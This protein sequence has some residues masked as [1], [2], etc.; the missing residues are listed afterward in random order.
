[1]NGFVLVLCDV[2]TDRP[3]A[4][5]QLAV[6]TD[7]SAI[8]E[9]ALQPLAR[10][11]NYAETVF[12][13]P[14]AADGDARI[15][16]FTPTA[17]IP[18]A[19]HPT[20]GTAVVLATP[21][22][23]AEVRLET[24][25]GIV[26]IALRFEPGRPAFGRMRQ[27]VPQVT[28]V[29]D[30]LAA[31]LLAALGVARSRL[32]VERYDNGLLH[33]FVVLDD[34]AAVARLEPDFGALARLARA[35]NTPLVG[36]NCLAGSGRTWKTRMFAPADGIPEDSATGS[37]AGSLSCHLARHGLIPFGQEIEVSQGAEIN[38]PS[39]LYARASGSRDGI[40]SVEVGG[41]AVIVAHGTFA[42][43]AVA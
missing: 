39:T 6:F 15:R 7:A 31:A 29:D 10:E 32:P 3:L 9:T 1:M 40:T 25:V 24:G 20:L 5:N 30:T 42:A 26:P 21:D 38:R 2:F 16:I 22:R 43:E 23:R 27:P 18:F 36:F 12:V 11:T 41:H 33:L 13:Y 8:P 37:A 19:G 14:P 35:S 28:P 4:G 34:P 17:E